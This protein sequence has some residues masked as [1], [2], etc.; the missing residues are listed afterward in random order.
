MNQLRVDEAITRVLRREQDANDA[1]AECRRQAQAAVDEARARARRILDRAEDRAEALQR[2]CDAAVA[3]AIAELHSGEA[4]ESGATAPERA[5][6]AA[7]PER[8]DMLVRRLAAEILG[9]RE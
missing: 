6:D 9:V 8:V 4:A 3:V 5:N 2:H 7:A 1:V